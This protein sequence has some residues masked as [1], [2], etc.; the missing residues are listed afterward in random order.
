M[1]KSA[2]CSVDRLQSYRTVAYQTI[3]T[4]VGDRYK[5]LIRTNTFPVCWLL[6]D[7]SV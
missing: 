3:A 6:Y 4:T 7:F 5:V 2:D 1:D